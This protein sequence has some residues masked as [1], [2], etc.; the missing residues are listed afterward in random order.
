LT[1]STT[2]LEV[3]TGSAESTTLGN[4]AIQLASLAGE[5]D[6]AVGVS[7]SGVARWASILS[8]ASQSDEASDRA[9][10]VSG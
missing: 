10:Q 3:I 7:A 9:P 8:N 2:G 1:A 6:P 5:Y 4:F